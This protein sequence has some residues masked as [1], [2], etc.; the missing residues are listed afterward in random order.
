MK[1]NLFG[2]LLSSENMVQNL[3]NMM[4]NPCQKHA[5]DH[6]H[7][8]SSMRQRK[9]RFSSKTFNNSHSPFVLFALLFH[10]RVMCWRR[11]FISLG[12]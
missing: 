4:Q 9:K 12:V 8:V 2:G 7:V 5:Q 1:T 3:M 11:D 6:P 10:V